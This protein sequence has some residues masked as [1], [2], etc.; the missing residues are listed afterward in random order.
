MGENLIDVE[1]KGDFATTESF[2][3]KKELN[4]FLEELTWFDLV[5]IK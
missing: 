5:Q 1:F 3:S 2:E 4:E